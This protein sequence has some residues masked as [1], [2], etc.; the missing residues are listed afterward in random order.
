MAAP[1]SHAE[2]GRGG[3]WGEEAFLPILPVGLWS[4]TPSLPHWCSRETDVPSSFI[5]RKPIPLWLSNGNLTPDCKVEGSLL[6]CCPS[7]STTAVHSPRAKWHH[8][9]EHE[10]EVDH[11]GEPP[12]QR[13]REEDP[14]VGH[15]G[16]LPL[17]GLL[18]RFRTSSKHKADLF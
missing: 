5:D 11:P 16:E 6:P 12:L 15:L 3:P 1:G 18:Q 4:G 7:R 8:S 17:W 13:Q 2:S 10:A 9:P 14:L